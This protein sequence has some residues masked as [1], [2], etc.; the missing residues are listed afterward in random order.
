[1]AYR[2]IVERYNRR[3]LKL[4]DRWDSPFSYSYI[5][6]SFLVTGITSLYGV[7]LTFSRVTTNLITQKPILI[8]TTLLEPRKPGNEFV[9]P[10][11]QC[12]SQVIELLPESEKGGS[13]WCA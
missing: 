4:I 8:P 7:F 3:N 11:W 2:C 13:H 5:P 1:M 10:I 12:W 9:T 6:H